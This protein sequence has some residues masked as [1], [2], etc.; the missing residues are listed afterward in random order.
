MTIDQVLEL[1]LNHGSLGVFAA[2][3]IWQHTKSQTRLDSMVKSFQAQIKDLQESSRDRE[4]ELQNE[5][6]ERE[7]NQRDK[8]EAVI[9][10]YND[11]RKQLRSNL[12]S[13]IKGVA[14]R[15]RDIESKVET[16]SIS[17]ESLK[18]IINDM[19]V[20]EVARQAVGKSK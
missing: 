16:I 18:A 6:L 10:G 9:L 7:K 11:E 13:Q 19:K 15:I 1:L 8:F 17:V 12:A 14:I 3:L 4:K 2:F 5:S 20:R